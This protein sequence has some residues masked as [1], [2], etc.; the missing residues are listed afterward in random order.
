MTDIVFEEPLDVEVVR[1]KAQRAWD[2]GLIKIAQL[3]AVIP[4]GPELPPKYMN[5]DN[6]RVAP[7]Q[8][9]NRGTCV[10]QSSAALMDYIHLWITKEV[11]TGTIERDIMVGDT[12]KRDQLYDQ[13]FSAQAIYEYSRTEGGV[14]DP[15]GSYCNAAIRAL[16]KK[17]CCLES[18][19]WT[20][21]EA[22]AVWQTPYPCTVVETDLE[23]GTHKIEGYAALRTLYSLKRAIVEHGAVVGAINI[24]ENYADNTVVVNGVTLFD[25]NLQDPR[26]GLAGSHALCFV[27][28]DDSNSRLYFRHSWEGWTELG[29]I[30]YKYWDEAGG[31]FWVALDTHESIIGT[32]V[33]VPVVMEAIGPQNETLQATVSVNGV[34]IGVTPVKVSLEKGTAAT[35]MVTCPGYVAM[36]HTF[37]VD[38]SL[39]SYTFRLE[40]LTPT[41]TGWWAKIIDWIFSLFKR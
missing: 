18:Q 28:Y 15:A 23:A 17:G 32:M 34:T 25:G 4:E 8:Q 39:K 16:L 29:S 3:G 20:S 21:K 11:P 31:D 38:D 30:S 37:A 12:A 10:G 36:E 7:R 27:G 13:S 5:S 19:W 33:Y 22:R 24:Y 1:A 9:G 41:K 26:G 2:Y 40:A 14:T 6:G 35:I